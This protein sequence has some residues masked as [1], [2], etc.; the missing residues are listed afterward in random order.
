MWESSS[1]E[2]EEKEEEVRDGVERQSDTQNES[3]VVDVEEVGNM[4]H[5]ARG[6]RSTGKLE[7]RKRLEPREMVTP[8]LRKTLS[9]QGVLFFL[10]PVDVHVI[11]TESL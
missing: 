4:M 7:I 8:L 10:H 3:G 1:E 5:R 6:S 2:E 9:K 11:Y